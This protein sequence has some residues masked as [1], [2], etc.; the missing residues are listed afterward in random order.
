MKNR[1]STGMAAAVAAIPLLAHAQPA[2]P[3]YQSAFAGYHA[4]RE[5]QPGAWRA[6]NDAMGAAALKPPAHAGHGMPAA[7]KATS[8]PAA[9]AVPAA[10]APAGPAHHH[11]GMH[12]APAPG[13][14]P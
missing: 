2:E 3:A 5:P 9:P 6:L 4:Y 11:P 10:A 1:F 13:G 7:Q 12:P 14:Q 8:A